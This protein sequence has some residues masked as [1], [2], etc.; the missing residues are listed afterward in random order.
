MYRTGHGAAEFLEFLTAGLALWLWLW[1]C[2]SR[3]SWYKHT[4]IWT[5]DGGIVA[6][7][8]KTM[9]TDRAV[10][11]DAHAAVGIV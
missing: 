6:T 10:G 5:G 1:L 3:V 4:I 2:P 11:E 9:N 7:G 8:A